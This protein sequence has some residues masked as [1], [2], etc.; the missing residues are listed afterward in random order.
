MRRKGGAIPALPAARLHGNAAASASAATSSDHFVCAAKP[1]QS[2]GAQTITA[3]GCR[4][5]AIVFYVL[6]PFF[7]KE[8]AA[9]PQPTATV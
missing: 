8:A 2:N 6:R 3:R 7:V 5:A 9:A 4:V 1:G